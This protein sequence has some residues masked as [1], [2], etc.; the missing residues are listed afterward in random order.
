MILVGNLQRNRQIQQ[1]VC[2]NCLTMA[3]AYSVDFDVFRFW[4][5][6]IYT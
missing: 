3:L 4:N 1:G 6:F 2:M 5:N